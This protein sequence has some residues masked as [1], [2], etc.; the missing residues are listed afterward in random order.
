MDRNIYIPKKSILF[1]VYYRPPEGSEYLSKN[2]NNLL[3]TQLE[4]A[5]KCNKETIIMGDFN[6][7]YN[8]P[9]KSKPFK[10]IMTSVGYKQ[11]IKT[12]T[13]MTENSSTLNDLCFVNTPSRI[14]KSVVLPLSQSDHDMIVCIRKINI[15]KYK[16]RT[17]HEL[18]NS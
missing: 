3:E 16:P 5:N 10:D 17:I 13:R 12:S 4:S 1:G 14:S 18:Q 6:V 11:T 9:R 2:F 8:E 7:D 15:L